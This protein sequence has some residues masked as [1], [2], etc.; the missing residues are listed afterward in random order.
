MENSKRECYEPRHTSSLLTVAQKTRWNAIAKEWLA[1]CICAKPVKASYPFPF[2]E[3]G[4]P[5]K[6]NCLT[7]N[8][9]SIYYMLY[10]VIRLSARSFEKTGAIPLFQGFAGLFNVGQRLNPGYLNLDYRTPL[11]RGKVTL[12]KLFLQAMNFYIALVVTFC[13]CSTAILFHFELQHKNLWKCDRVKEPECGN[14]MFCRKKIHLLFIHKYKCLIKRSAQDQSRIVAIVSDL[15][16]S[17][18]K[19]RLLPPHPLRNPVHPTPRAFE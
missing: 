10:I 14:D 3:D 6:A 13:I 9:S 4:G 11:H 7:R 5:G 17:Q 19:S 1:A 8:L 15:I 16:R 2:V 12:N 18:Q